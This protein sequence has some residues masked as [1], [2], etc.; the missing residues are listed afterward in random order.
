MK[1]PDINSIIDEILSSYDRNKI[2]MIASHI[3]IVR[4][5]SKNGKKVKALNIWFDKKRLE[6]IIEKIRSKNSIV[7]VKIRLNE[8]RLNVGDWI[9]IVMIAGEVREKVFP[10]LIEMVDMIKKEASRKEE[11]Y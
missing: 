1:I 2:G 3:G 4:G 6:E 5:Y 11:I 8:G 9:M 7:D 10:A